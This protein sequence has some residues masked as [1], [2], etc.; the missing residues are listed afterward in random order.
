MPAAELKLSKC[1]ALPQAPRDRR[2][3]ESGESAE[4]RGQRRAGGFRCLTGGWWPDIVEFLSR[5]MRADR[6]LGE[7]SI[8]QDSAAGRQEFE[9]QMERRRLW[10]PPHP[11]KLARPLLS[12]R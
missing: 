8:G 4:Q 1:R 12:A 10:H 3:S 5:A 7:H 9:R 6:L 11:G 2:S